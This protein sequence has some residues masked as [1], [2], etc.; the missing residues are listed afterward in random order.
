MNKAELVEAIA[1][2]AK[3]SKAYAGRALDATIICVSKALKK[4][5]KVS[6]IGFGTFTVTK[7]EAR[8]G[9][10]PKNG[11]SIQIKAKKIAKFKAGS[12]LSATVNK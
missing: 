11:D 8:V 1:N 9:R 5:E 10:N 7:R 4:G 2:E 3:I 12:E 6:L